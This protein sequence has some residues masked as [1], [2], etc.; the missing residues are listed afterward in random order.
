MLD[1]VADAA[2]FVRRLPAFLRR[3]A[4]HAAR[5]ILAERRAHREARARA[6]L[7]DALL[8][9]PQ[10][11]YHA[12]LRAA[13]CEPRELDALVARDGIDRALRRLLARP[14]PGAAATREA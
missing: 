11:P 9:Q 10:S 12:L 3:S 1:D 4:T 14:R 7:R 13:G 6:F 8:S 5:G 2:R